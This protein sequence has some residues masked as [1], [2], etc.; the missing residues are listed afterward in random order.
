MSWKLLPITNDKSDMNVGSIYVIRLALT[1]Y[2]NYRASTVQNNLDVLQKQRDA[3]IEKLKAATKYNTTQELLKKYGGTPTPKVKS[4][5]SA[6]QN[7]SPN[8]ATPKGGRTAMIPP[9]T[10]NIPGRIASASLQNPPERSAVA[11]RRPLEPNVSFSPTEMAAPRQYGSAIYDESADFAPNAFSTAPQYIQPEQGSRWYDRIMDVL[12]GEDEMLP[13]NRLALICSHCRLVNGQASPGVKR[14][15]DIG[16][17]RCSGCGTMNGEEK[18]AEKIIAN[19]KEHAVSKIE[20]PKAGLENRRVSGDDGIDNED[21]EVDDGH[22]SDVTQYSE[23]ME[24][25]SNETGET[26]EKVPKH[27][28]EPEPPKR[29]VG[30]P[31]GSGK[32]ST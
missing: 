9:P 25:E 13:R 12:L 23:D 19:I 29:R 24:V 20:K 28:V 10:A 8:P 7:P 17:W 1:T 14:L 6:A 27:P 32:K 15:E 21:A 30:R 4:T 16:R 22:E 5:G 2:Y 3:T 31:K 26:K 11:T 18:D